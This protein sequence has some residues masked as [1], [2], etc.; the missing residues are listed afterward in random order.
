MNKWMHKTTLRKERI[1]RK[2][3]E[4]IAKR[5]ENEARSRGTK[6]IRKAM[7]ENV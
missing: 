4:S 2:K 5:E 3:C 1:E 6:K 7:E